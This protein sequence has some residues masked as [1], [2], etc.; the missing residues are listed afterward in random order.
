LL[1]AAVAWAS[2]VGH[3]LVSLQI[4]R[5]FYYTSFGSNRPGHQQGRSVN[6]I[7]DDST[8]RRTIIEQPTDT[9]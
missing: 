9:T 6:C 2:W 5:D 4:G 3:R 1:T 8:G 7:R